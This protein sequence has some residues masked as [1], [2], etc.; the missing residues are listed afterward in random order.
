L[1]KDP[2]VIGGAVNYWSAAITVNN[3]AADTANCAGTLVDY[4]VEPAGI[5]LD[6]FL[7]GSNTQP[8]TD[9]DGPF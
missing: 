6:T 1:Y 8:F 9:G 5:D 2:E 4:T 7:T 3:S